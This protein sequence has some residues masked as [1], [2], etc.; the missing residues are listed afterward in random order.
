[1][2]ARASGRK[3]P[4]RVA[5]SPSRERSGMG[6]VPRRYLLGLGSSLGDKLSALAAACQQ[7]SAHPQIMLM[8]RAAI[9]A[10][11]PEG[12]AKAEFANSAVIVATDLPPVPL[13]SAVK[14]IEKALGRKPRGRWQDREIDIDLLIEHQ[15]PVFYS[16]EPKLWLPHK[17][18]FAR[19]FVLAPAK[20]IAATWQHPYFQLSIGAAWQQFI[21]A[22]PKAASL[23]SQ[24]WP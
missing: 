2:T 15:A 4:P 3:S 14:A 13:L 22:Q 11:P 10:T 24:P 6:E 8:E 17:L 19:S 9:Y 20:D 5:A 12:A 16:A 23:P 21:A 18:M 7:L 1:M